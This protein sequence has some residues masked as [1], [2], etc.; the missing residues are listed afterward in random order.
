MSESASDSSSSKVDA[1]R[2][3]RMADEKADPARAENEEL[4]V[5]TEDGRPGWKDESGFRPDENLGQTPGPPP[6]LVRI[7]CSEG[8]ARKPWE[9][10]V[11]GGWLAA[12][13]RR[14]RVL[15]VSVPLVEDRKR[16][17]RSASSA[18]DCFAWV[19]CIISTEGRPRLRR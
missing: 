13:S 7:D 6:E 5:G 9:L 4:R 11:R 19:D 15:G 18:K 1:K 3:S 17:V 8:D 12:R 10:D 16:F 2:E 14:L